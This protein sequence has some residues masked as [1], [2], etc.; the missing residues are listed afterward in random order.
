MARNFD[1]YIFRKY[2]IYIAKYSVMILLED[3]TKQSY[4]DLLCIP[5]SRFCMSSHVGDLMVALDAGIHIKLC[6]QLSYKY[7]Q[8]F[9]CTQYTY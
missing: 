5:K 6:L 7:G 9:M 1:I 4:P 3:I 2:P 8:D